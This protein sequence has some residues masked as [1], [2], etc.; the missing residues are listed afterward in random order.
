MYNS[1][2]A[3]R[4]PNI[5]F[6]EPVRARRRTICRS[7]EAL[8]SRLSCKPGPEKGREQRLSSARDGE[9]EDYHGMVERL[10]GPPGRLRVM[11]FH[12]G[13]AGE[14]GFDFFSDFRTYSILKFMALQLG[15]IVFP[16]NFV[17]VHELRI[18]EKGGKEH[19]ATYSDYIRDENGAG[20][21]TGEA[22]KLFDASPDREMAEC[23]RMRADAEEHR[24]T[25]GLAA[26]VEKL[27]EAGIIVPHPE[28]NYHISGG[29]IVFFEV[30]SIEAGAALALARRRYADGGNLEFM[31]SLAAIHA[32]IL[33]F[34]MSAE[35]TR[36]ALKQRDGKELDMKSQRIL[37][38]LERRLMSPFS[39][40]CDAVIL[41]Y[42]RGEEQHIADGYFIEN[43]SF[44]IPM[45]GYG[46]KTVFDCG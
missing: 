7:D 44:A 32:A 18:F 46:K 42:L 1:Y 8:V 14:A 16:D 2:Y 24:R 30:S 31:D 43:L 17:R 39:S 40:L 6:E 22:R 9:L 21:R 45:G 26:A 23:I 10:Q 34:R 41:K 29:N 4:H 35:F 37:P 38:E 28:A 11:E 20:R 12:F 15:S 13:A 5:R 3:L 19:Y 33:R 36:I 27:R 25:P